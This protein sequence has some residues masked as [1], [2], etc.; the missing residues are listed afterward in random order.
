MASRQVVVDVSEE[1]ITRVRIGQLIE[2][3]L[4]AY[5]DY[6]I[7]GQ[8]DQITPSAD[9]ARGTIRVRIKMREADDRVLP[10]MGVKVRFL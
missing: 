3:Q 7:G 5:P 2:A 6:K 8:V 1:M 4:I 10:D 9:R